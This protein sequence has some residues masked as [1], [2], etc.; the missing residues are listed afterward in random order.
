ME[1]GR[2]KTE[3]MFRNI[4]GQKGFPLLEG[5]LG[6][7]STQQEAQLNDVFLCQL[8]TEVTSFSK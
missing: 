7:L 6:P 2:E 8:V 3:D 4:R 5:E 1:S